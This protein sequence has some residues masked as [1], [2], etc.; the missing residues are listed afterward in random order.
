M[1]NYPLILDRLLNTPL[2]MHPDKLQTVAAVVLRRAGVEVNVATQTTIVN[3][4]KPTAGPAQERVLQR[5]YGGPEGR[6]YLLA[7]GVAV[8]EVEGS[9]AHRQGYIGTSS[10]VMGYDG[11]AAQFAAAMEDPE[12]R[13]ILFDLHSPGGEVSGCF[14]LADRIFQARSVKKIVA[15]VDEMAFS[16]AYA[17]AAA[18]DEVILAS[19][20]AAVGSV[21]AALI[22]F[23]FQGELEQKGCKP[24]L[25][26]SGER[27]LDLNPFEDLPAAV[28]ERTQERVEGTGGIFV[29]RVAQWR[30][31]AVAAVDGTDAD[32]FQGQDALKVGFADAIGA[33]L[34]VFDALVADTRASL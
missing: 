1:T 31:L 13:G 7:D 2:F 12:V 8:I 22:H 17:I 20:T 24:T 30:G 29:E 28:V 5:R 26:K 32:W 15:L 14:A 3:Q 27:K 21:G 18:C 23:S 11:I 33:P 6:P 34:D 9:L 4:P 25:F 10:G 16:A 19:E